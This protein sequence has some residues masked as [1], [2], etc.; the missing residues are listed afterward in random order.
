[1][2]RIATSNRIRADIGWSICAKYTLVLGSREVTS[3]AVGEYFSVNK[4]L[5]VPHEETFFC[6]RLLHG[7]LEVDAR[8]PPGD[9]DRTAF[10]TADCEQEWVDSR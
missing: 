4:R 5:S 2:T 3:I 8:S 10:D 6:C 7:S 9:G 1:M